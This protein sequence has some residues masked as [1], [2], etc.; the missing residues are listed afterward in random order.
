MTIKK[1]LERKNYD[2][3]KIHFG[4]Q[5]LGPTC[6]WDCG[7]EKLRAGSHNA[8]CLRPPFPFQQK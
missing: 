3:N 2:T 4:I 1:S 7:L 8:L 5:V 6:V